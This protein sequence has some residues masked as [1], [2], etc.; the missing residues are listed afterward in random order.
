MQ[1]IN[2]EHRVMSIKNIL[3]TTCL[4]LI[5]SFSISPKSYAEKAHLVP[6]RVVVL[7]FSLL[8]EV[9]SLGIKP[10]GIASNQ[11]A[12]GSNPA[13]L[14]PMIKGITSVGTRQQPS[15]ERIL[16]LKPDLI[17][18]DSNFQRNI[19]G[20]LKKI[21][22]TIMMNGVLGQPEQQMKNLLFLGKL[23]HREEKARKIV[24]KFEKKYHK[25]EIVGKA[26]S[27]SVIM[28]FAEPNGIFMALT[29]NATT[30]GIL[31][32]IGK[33]NLITRY[34]ASQVIPMTVEK[35]L[36]ENPDS[37]VL[38]VTN[39]K[40]GEKVAQRMLQNPLWGALRAVKDKH[41]YVM[42]RNLWAIDHG[43]TAMTL[44]L[45]QASESGFLTMSPEKMNFNISAV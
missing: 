14:K 9:L 4:V 5:F 38:L 35:L 13:Y 28:G 6:K 15:L 10:I 33:R 26:H 12:E 24:A 32:S 7:E 45:G 36:S 22:P 41:V 27:A 17:I 39:G 44:M 19:A 30:T 16:S 23:F 21:A 1:L 3:I 34:A 40:G 2:K 25:E 37:I 29:K 8:D 11:T 43:V 42:S 18:A 31:D 20:K